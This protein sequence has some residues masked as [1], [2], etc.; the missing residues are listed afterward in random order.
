M[1]SRITERGTCRVP[2]RIEFRDLPEIFIQEKCN[3]EISKVLISMSQPHQSDPTLRQRLEPDQSVMQKFE[4]FHS[5]SHSVIAHWIFFKKKVISVS[6]LLCSFLSR[7]NVCGGQQCCSG[8]ALA[9][10]TNRCIKRE[11]KKTPILTHLV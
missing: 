2:D 5:F 7:P 11:L 1:D 6:F 4:A 8:W 9:P 3:Y 10:G